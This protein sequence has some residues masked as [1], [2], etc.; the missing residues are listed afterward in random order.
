MYYIYNKL[1]Q[2]VEVKRNGITIAGYY[3]DQLGL[4][5]KKVDYLEEKTTIYI[6]GTETE[7]IYEEIYGHDDL[8]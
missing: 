8:N 2:L 7:P 3:Y 4:R 5:Y 6:Y 1:N